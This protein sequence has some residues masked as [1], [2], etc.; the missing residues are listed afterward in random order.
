[1]NP[2]DI[3]LLKSLENLSSSY[4][5]LLTKY[6][7][8]EQKYFAVQINLSLISSN[9][10]DLIGKDERDIEIMQRILELIYDSLDYKYIKKEN[11]E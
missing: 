10:R 4:N 1:M 11:E 5:D 2:I 6:Q 8:L 3:D 9:V 7:V